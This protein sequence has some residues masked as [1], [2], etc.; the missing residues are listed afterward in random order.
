LQPG[1]AI[2]IIVVILTSVSVELYVKQ[3]SMLVLPA[4]VFTPPMHASLFF[5]SEHPAF[6]P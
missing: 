2:I 3:S 6:P 1:I 5:Q 4:S